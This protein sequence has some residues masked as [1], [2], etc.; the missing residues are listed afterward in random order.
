M[1][2][3][4]RTSGR[5]AAGRLTWRLR[6]A[7]V[8]TDCV[9]ARPPRELRAEEFEK[10]V[11]LEAH[12]EVIVK[13]LTRHPRKTDRLVRRIVFCVDQERADAMRRAL[14]PAANCRCIA[15]R[16]PAVTERRP[17]SGL[18]RPRRSW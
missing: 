18:V 4:S 9:G 15:S 12:T 13:H 3:P 8:V 11:S 5:A 14:D 10:V 7:G 1:T 2:L 16:I 6:G 17:A